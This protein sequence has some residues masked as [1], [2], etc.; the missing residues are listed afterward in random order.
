MA[1]A[2]AKNLAYAG[3]Q[4]RGECW[5]GNTLGYNLVSDSD[6]NMKCSANSSE[7]CGGSW[8]N[9]VYSAAAVTPPAPAAKYVGCYT[10]SSTRALPTQLGWSNATVETCVAAAKAKNLAYAGLQYSGECWAGNTLGYNLVSDSDCNT[11]CSA[12]PS[13]MCGGSWRSSV[14][15][16][17][18]TTTVAVAVTP[19][20]SSIT[21]GKTA[22]LTA[23][24]TGS[25]DKAVTWSVQEGPAGGSVTSAGLYT[26]P[27]T[28]GT[29]HVIAQSHADPA[30]SDTATVTA[31]TP[32]PAPAPTPA[33]AAVAVSLSPATADVDACQTY[34]FTASVT[35]TSNTAVTWSTLEGP[36]GGSISTT[37][38]YTA[39]A[40]AG[41]YH[42]VATSQADTTKTTTATVTVTERIVSVAVNP[43]TVTASQGGTAQLSATVTTTCG[44]FTVTN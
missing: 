29:Y 41:T 33:P 25:T 38:V 10:D 28:A 18:G 13:E 34:T 2:K 22:Q 44:A 36:T 35:G 1:A 30:K 15:S 9:S 43:Q 42:V 40:T 24:V 6:C 31:S 23:T 3:L 17:Q 27:Q 26:A 14:Y 7:T 21:V 37:G 16:T 19:K 20:T 11:K 39:P 8:R 32:P 5:A 12:N 4:Y